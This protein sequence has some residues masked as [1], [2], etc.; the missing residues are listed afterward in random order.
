M[1][2]AAASMGIYAKIQN[3]AITSVDM[4]VAG[5]ASVITLVA[6]DLLGSIG[7]IIA[8]VGIIV[9]PI[10]SGDTALRSLRLMVAEY[11]HYDQSKK[12]NRVTLSGIIFIICA[13]ILVFAKVSASGFN[14]LW[15]YF[16]FANQTIAIFAFAMITVYLY[17]RSKNYIISLIPGMFYAFIIST[18]IINAKI[19]LNVPINIAYVCGAIFTL[20]WAV[21]TLKCA[22]NRKANRQNNTANSISDSVV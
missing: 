11:L 5:T 19:G 4:S 2:W 13:A 8:I 12:S 18:F 1:I 6:R 20:V 9:L 22:K 7:G 14:I 17:E 3:G 21:L 10:T 15:R 16:A